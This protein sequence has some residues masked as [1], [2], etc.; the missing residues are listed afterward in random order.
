MA[1][2]KST[3]CLRWFEAALSSSHSSTREQRLVAENAAL[4]AEIK[5][6]EAKLK[7]TLVRQKELRDRL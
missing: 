1:S 4:K 3:P 2:K 5:A 6:V 7:A